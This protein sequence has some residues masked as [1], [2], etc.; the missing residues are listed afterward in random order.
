MAW[1]LLEDVIDS[2]GSLQILNVINSLTE[3]YFF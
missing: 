3:C 1:I 2:L